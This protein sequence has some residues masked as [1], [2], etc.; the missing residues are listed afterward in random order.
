MSQYKQISKLAKADLLT[1]KA[2]A[3]G[4]GAPNPKNMLIGPGDASD[5]VNPFAKYYPQE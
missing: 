1:D 2:R 3:R 5:Y 4:I